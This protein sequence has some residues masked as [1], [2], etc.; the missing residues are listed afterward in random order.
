V[1]AVRLELLA[2]I[3]RPLTIRSISKTTEARFGFDIFK[4]SFELN[5]HQP[6]RFISTILKR[7]IDVTI[8]LSSRRRS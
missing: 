5:A 2:E 7:R 6:E 4:A 3:R 1:G 8:F